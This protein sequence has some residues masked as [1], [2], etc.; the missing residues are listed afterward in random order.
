[1]AAVLRFLLWTALLL[2][3]L[4]TLL[5]F[6]VLRLWRVPM[7]DPVLEAALA[8]TLAA[9]DLVLLSKV[10]EPSFGDLVVC[11]EPDYPERIVVGRVYAEAGDSITFAQ[12]KPVVNGKPPKIERQC[13]PAQF[14]VIHPDEV[15]KEIHQQCFW[16][17]MANR[18]HQTGSLAGFPPPRGGRNV[19][20]PPGHVYLVSDNRLFPYDSRDYGPVLRETCRET[21]VFRLL[22]RHGW[23]DKDARMS[24]IQ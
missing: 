18:L 16:E 23:G 9:G 11:P 15:G 19:E 21:V 24:M 12:G 1:M 2:G 7:N 14:T 8:P 10:T 3:A 20:V 6:T 5:H 4:G 13:T 22:S 17:A